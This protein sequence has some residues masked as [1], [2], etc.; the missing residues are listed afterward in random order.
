MD[1]ET[2]RHQLRSKA[3]GRTGGHRREG[4]YKTALLQPTATASTASTATTA[5]TAATA[6]PAATAATCCNCYS[7]AEDVALD[8]ERVAATDQQP[9]EDGDNL[10]VG[11]GFRAEDTGDCLGVGLR[12]EQ[13]RR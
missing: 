3:R 9:A 7:P 4:S 10:E 6:T 11:L 12:L 8:G 1:T 5:A 13:K 2:G